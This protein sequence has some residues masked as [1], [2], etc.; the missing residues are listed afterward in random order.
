MSLDEFVVKYQVQA[1]LKGQGIDTDGVYGPQCMDLMHEYIRSV[2]GIS[3]LSILAAPTAAQVFINFSNLTGHDLFVRI[4]N[5]PNGIP[6]KGDLI[7]F[8]PY[9]G[10]YGIAG[11]V[12]VYL[13]GDLYTLITYDQNYPT[14]SLP[15]IRKHSYVTANNGPCLGWI[16]KR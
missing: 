1:L 10:L 6:Q 9:P 3:D 7:F 8:K 12:C 5:T 13:D 16:R 4:A 2:L 14:W 11:H 15:A